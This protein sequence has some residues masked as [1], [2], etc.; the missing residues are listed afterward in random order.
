MLAPAFVSHSPLE[1]GAKKCPLSCVMGVRG[2]EGEESSCS[3]QL[4]SLLKR[5]GDVMSTFKSTEEK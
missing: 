5:G 2:S 3:K 4:W 1:K